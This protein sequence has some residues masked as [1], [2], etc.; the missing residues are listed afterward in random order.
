MPD[1]VIAVARN[2]I[3]ARL[4]RLEIQLCTELNRPRRLRIAAGVDGLIDRSDHSEDRWPGAKVAARIRKVRMVEHVISF[5]PQLQVTGTFKPSNGSVFIYLDVGVI[6]PGTMK[7]IT[8][9]VALG[10]HSIPVH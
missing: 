3:P 8:L 1:A 9:H 5:Q 4:L 6:E 7:E 10:L 2:I